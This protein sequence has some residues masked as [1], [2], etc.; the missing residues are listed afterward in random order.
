MVGTRQDPEHLL[1]PVSEVAARYGASA[2]RETPDEHEAYGDTKK[3][4]PRPIGVPW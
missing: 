3:L 1:Y 2:E 4:E